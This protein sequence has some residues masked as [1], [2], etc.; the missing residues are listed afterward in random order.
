MSVAGE[1]VVLP[2]ALET[3]QSKVPASADPAEAMEYVAEVAPLMGVPSRRH[4]KASGPLPV[5]ATVKEAAVPRQA[6]AL[7]GCVLTVGGVLRVSVAGELV[8]LPQAL[9]TTQS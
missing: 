5:A 8:V 6:D 3:T 7:K 2:Q 4:W 1:L 9:E